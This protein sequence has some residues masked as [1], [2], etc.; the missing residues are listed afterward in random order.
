MRVQRALIICSLLLSALSGA[1]QQH[2]VELIAPAP[3]SVLP[4]D[5]VTLAFAIINRGSVADTY[6]LRVEVSPRLQL[7][8]GPGAIAVTPGAQEPLFLTL[9]VPAGTP[10]GDYAILLEAVSQTAPSVRA[11]AR[12]VLTVEAMTGI[13]IRA[14][15]TKEVE[16][17][18][19]IFLIFTVINRGNIV[20]NLRLETATRSGYATTVEPPL[21]ELPPGTSKSVSVSVQVPS[22]ASPGF[23]PVT[24]TATSLI[25][26]GIG[27][28][29]TAMLTVLPTLPQ[30]VPTELYLRSPAELSIGANVDLASSSL[31]PYISFFTVSA[32]PE[33]QRFLLRFRLSETIRQQI[34][35]FLPVGLTDFLFV[36]EVRS[37]FVR[38]GDLTELPL[39]LLSLPRRG[40]ELGFRDGLSLLVT[41]GDQT[42]PQRLISLNFLGPVRAGLVGLHTPGANPYD[43]FGVYFRKSPIFVEGSIAEVSVGTRR[44]VS[45]RILPSFG[46]MT[47]GAEFLR[48]EPG[49]PMLTLP[50]AMF[51]DVQA[52]TILGGGGLGPISV[53]SLISNSFNDLFGD[54]GIQQIAKVT[55][56]GRL[57]IY[58]LYPGLPYITWD[59]RFYYERSNDPPFALISTDR[60]FQMVTFAELTQRIGY[61]LSFIDST[62]IDNISSTQTKTHEIR[63]LIFVR[64]FLG[65]E[66]GSASLSLR[67]MRMFDPVTDITITEE[68]DLL[69]RISL[70]TPKF[71][72]SFVAG[73]SSGVGFYGSLDLTWRG[74]V[75]LSLLMTFAEPTSLGVSAQLSTR[76]TLPFASVFVKGRVEGYLFVDTNNNAKRDPGES[77]LANV[78]LTLDG[79]L[80]RTDETGYFRF[81]PVDPG[82]YKLEIS[83]MPIG[84][85]P[86]VMLPIAVRLGVNQIV[87]LEIPVRPVATVR[88]RV[89]DDKNRNGKPDADEPGLGGVRLLALGPKTTE[90]RTAED[91]Q[92]MLQLE[93]GA[94]T[95]SIDRTTLPKRYEMTTA[96]SVAVTL[97][98][99]Q[100][101]TVDF[102][103]AE[104][105]RPILF[106]P[107]AEFSYAPAQPRVGERVTFDGSLSS[108]SDGQIVL[109]EWDFNGDGRADA[110][111]KIVEHIFKSA[112]N[113]SVT[114]TVTDNDDLKNSETKIILVRP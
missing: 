60:I 33:E 72:A 90:M 54:P 24:L 64:R 88:G 114:L 55:A 95:I 76:F 12:A 79:Q 25:R 42:P 34:L 68:Q 78:L 93:P 51:T 87:A 10:A 111:G 39:H 91:G 9:Y 50:P 101:M 104:V 37:F 14:P 113:F 4:N 46:G 7:V 77:G 84:F 2:G 18:T 3:R 81:P 5:F 97:Q 40:V 48:V 22:T 52:I 105:P 86:T 75:D 8:G 1:A 47:V 89:F 58:P 29:A 36:S 108:D 83:R 70:A 103:A 20:E 23:E 45:M 16:P 62:F 41:F 17:G 15:D 44:M 61:I 59:S 30:A 35:N 107:N 71:G 74:P 27:G 65:L 96:S 21:L 85:S 56:Q 49:F 98:T 67:W 106:A 82:S 102:G 32:L 13:A 112:G 73:R 66:G 57:T 109:Y 43:L 26:E 53:A 63:T 92:Y 94:H 19:E 110:Q 99:G 28:S 6:D 69:L 31:T 38:L 100:M 80:A 11:Q